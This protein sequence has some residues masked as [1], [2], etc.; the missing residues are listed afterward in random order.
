[1]PSGDRGL[2]EPTPVTSQQP[3][4]PE[5]PREP[6]VAVLEASS[7]WAKTGLIVR[8]GDCY[9]ITVTGGCRDSSGKTFSPDGPTSRDKLTP[10]GATKEVLDNRAHWELFT[11]NHP[12]QMLM[13]KVG[14][15][16]T[17]MAVGAGITFISPGDGGL[18]FRLND[19]QL[20]DE[21]SRGRLS[22]ELGPVAS[23]EFVAPDG[24][25]TIITRVAGIKS[26]VFEPDG[27]RWEYAS[28]LSDDADDYP[29]LINGIRWW[30]ERDVRKVTQSKLL[31]TAEFS[32]AAGPNAVEPKVTL[33]P[34]LNNPHAEVLPGVSR[35]GCQTLRFSDPE[36]GVDEIYCVISR[37]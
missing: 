20:G 21:G 2:K 14:D 22:I 27:L 29:V 36:Q 18:A 16:A 6:Q 15:A 4:R 12:R 8:E 3:P 24:T 23:P 30:P 37:P 33:P 25:T 11:H 32:W 17:I 5:P 26:L 34:G 1:M 35:A 10:L 19:R 7:E 28:I 13:A 31:R 9:K